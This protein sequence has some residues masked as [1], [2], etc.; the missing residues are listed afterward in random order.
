MHENG[1]G[2]LHVLGMC[3]MDKRKYSHLGKEYSAKQLL[4]EYKGRKKRSRKVNASYIELLVSYKGIPVKLFF[5]R[6]SK[7][8]KW[9]LLITTDLSLTF[10]KAIAIYNIRWSIEVF[11]KEGKQYL[12]LGKSQANDFDAQI[13]DTTISMM[14]Y[15]LLTLHKR[16]AA[17]ETL[18][19]LFRKN[20]EYF[21]QL[22]LAE[23]LW[24]I[25]LE[26]LL[27]IIEIFEIDINEVMKKMFNQ[28]EYESKI[29]KM[30]QG[31]DAQQTDLSAIAQAGA[32]RFN[33]A[34]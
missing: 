25:F 34:A 31:L 3:R 19:E 24:G 26:L 10:N 29:L 2:L 16:F 18:G 21:L 33:K 12:N 9:H 14:Q 22:T 23:R 8:G 32:P 30:L 7:R 17:Y 28:P 6:Y 13:A 4:K 27:H 20:K 1:K 5:S 15:I 11:F